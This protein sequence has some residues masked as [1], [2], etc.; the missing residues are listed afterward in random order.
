MHS[1]EC[2]EANELF[3]FLREIVAHV[4]VAAA[5]KRPRESTA[6]AAPAMKHEGSSSADQEE[7]IDKD[8]TSGVEAP[9]K[10]QHSTR[11]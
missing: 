6:A 3:D 9:A 5:A 10:K 11:T 1:R 2:V 8:T 7:E 4:P